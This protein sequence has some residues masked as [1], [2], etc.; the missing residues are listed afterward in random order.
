MRPAKVCTIMI[1]TKGP[2]IRTGNNKYGKN[3]KLVM[4]QSL[5][6]VTDYTVEGDNT[7]IAC[8][9]KFLPESVQAGGTIYF[10]TAHLC[11]KY[12]E[13]CRVLV[14]NDVEIGQKKNMDLPGCVADQPHFPNKTRMTSLNLDSKS[15]RYDRC[16]F[17]QKVGGN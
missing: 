9:Y 10:A 17:C 1:E 4:G 5:E 2:E 7:K 8:S 3:I 13:W 16:F 15:D 14:K 6:I 11:A 12:S